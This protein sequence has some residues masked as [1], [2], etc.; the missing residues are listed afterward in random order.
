MI[1]VETNNYNENY[2][3]L[4][5]FLNDHEV[6]YDKE[7]VKELTLDSSMKA[8]LNNYFWKIDDLAIPLK[9]ELSKII[10]GF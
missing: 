1:E 7:K 3:K 5:N 10:K 2:E 8:D 6:N 4:I 9:R